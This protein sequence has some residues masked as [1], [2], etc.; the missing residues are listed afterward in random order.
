[1]LLTLFD[2]VKYSQSACAEHQGDAQSACV[3]SA[4]ALVD[5]SNAFVEPAS[6]G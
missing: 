5:H 1:M 4:G 6:L 3:T 2:L